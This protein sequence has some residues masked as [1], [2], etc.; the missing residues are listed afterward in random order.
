VFDRLQ[1]FSRLPWGAWR[2]KISTSAWP[3]VMAHFTKPFMA[4]RLLVSLNFPPES[5]PCETG[6]DRPFCLDG[7]DQRGNLRHLLHRS[8]RRFGFCRSRWP[9]SAFTNE[10]S[11]FFFHDSRKELVLRRINQLRHSDRIGRS[12]LIKPVTPFL[13]LPPNLPG[14]FIHGRAP[15]ANF[16]PPPPPPF[17]S[18]SF[19][20]KIIR[21]DVVVPLPSERE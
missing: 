13:P 1:L 20:G 4:S 9:E 17:S 7:G 12:C 6:I 3:S 15:I 2:R 19:L 8:R 21:P 16:V 11:I 10:P 14:Q 18:P 5:T